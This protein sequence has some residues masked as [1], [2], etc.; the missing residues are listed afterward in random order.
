MSYSSFCLTSCVTFN[1]IYMPWN[2]MLHT[3]TFALP[4]YCTIANCCLLVHNFPVTLCRSK[5]LVAL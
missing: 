1:T 2:F 3:E 4:V 5:I